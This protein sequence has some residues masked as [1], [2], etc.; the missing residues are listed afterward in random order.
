MK[1]DNS[2]R[3]EPWAHRG[4]ESIHGTVYA[5]VGIA[6]LAAFL[7]VA[8]KATQAP[9]VSLAAVAGMA[10]AGWLIA[11]RFTEGRDF[12]LTGDSIVGTILAIAVGAILLLGVKRLLDARLN[13]AENRQMLISG[14]S[15]IAA[16]V[17]FT[18][19]AVGTTAAVLMLV[20]LGLLVLYGAVRL[21]QEGRILIGGQDLSGFIRALIPIGKLLVGIAVIL[22]VRAIVGEIVGDQRTMPAH[23]AVLFIMVIL[24][25]WVSVLRT[26]SMAANRML[27]ASTLVAGTSIGFSGAAI[28]STLIRLQTE[29]A[30]FIPGEYRDT[31]VT[32]GYFLA[33]IGIILV[34]V[35]AVM[36]WARRRDI[37]QSQQRAAK[38]REAAEA[39]AQEL[40]AA[41]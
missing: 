5:V 18:A 35:A 37:V 19:V 28:R 34:L 41:S 29:S 11:L 17:I 33:N 23:V 25:L 31:Q 20:T 30:P 32:W 13:V 16:L 6:L 9:R 3:I 36:L 7:V 8:A 15:V 12:T 24:G 4:F 2:Y 27:M 26:P 10:V 14:A 40:A 1:P 39:S 21:L 38:Q 22:F